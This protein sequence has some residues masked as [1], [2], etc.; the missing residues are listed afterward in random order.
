MYASTEFKPEGKKIDVCKILDL[1]INKN[2]AAK[3]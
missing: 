3:E 1:F 2:D